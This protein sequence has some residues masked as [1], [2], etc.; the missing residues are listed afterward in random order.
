MGAVA[1]YF[2]GGGHAR[3]AAALIREGDRINGR[4]LTAEPEVVRT[5]LL[6]VLPDYIRPAITVD[7]IMSRGPQ[8]IAPDTPVQ[9]DYDRG[10][11]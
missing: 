7:Q 2:H 1:G 11:D 5:E 9:D 8:V 3:A 4:E 10:P 6:R